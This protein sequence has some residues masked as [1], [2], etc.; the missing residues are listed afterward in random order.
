M[1]KKD[2]KELKDQ[3]DIQQDYSSESEEQFDRD[4]D[5]LQSGR[6]NSEISPSDLYQYKYMRLVPNSE[7]D[8]R[9]LIDKDVV[10]AN[11]QKK[12]PDPEYQK[13]IAETIAAFKRVFVKIEK[14]I[15]A[16]EK[17]VPLIER[18]WVEQ[19]D[20]FGNK[21]LDKSG[22]PLMKLIEKPITK[23]ILV[24]DDTF[25]PIVEFLQAGF[26]Y[27]HVASRAM[28]D[29][30]EAILDRTTKLD[31]GIAKKEPQQQNKFIT[32]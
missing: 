12:L 11:L 2:R 30:R 25:G 29:E 17:G 19:L 26:K 16:D 10:L 6:Y 27:D 3:M 18:I 15:V 4:L 13:F 31:K 24:F 14:V 7:T 8:F 9:G 1:N 21:L 20:N 23:D 32:G 22:K 5:N 28:G